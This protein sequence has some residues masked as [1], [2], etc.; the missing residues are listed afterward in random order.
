MNTTATTPDLAEALEAARVSGA[1]GLIRIHWDALGYHVVA[2][3]DDGR[4]E[5]A[6]GTS[7]RG[8]IEHVAGRMTGGG[9]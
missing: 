6:K 7:A 2:C 5:Q 8:V 3:W 1:S 4:L 9:K